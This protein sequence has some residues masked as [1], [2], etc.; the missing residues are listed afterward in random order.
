MGNSDDFAVETARKSNDV[1]LRQLVY[2]EYPKPGFGINC[3][4][5]L[6][7]MRPICL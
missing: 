1:G 7:K 3:I 2:K 6:K 4:A 5:F